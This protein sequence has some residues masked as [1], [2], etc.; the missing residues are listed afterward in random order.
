MNNL[1]PK[2]LREF[3]YY[4]RK[5]P[6]YL[7]NDRNFVEHFKIWYDI[8]LSEKQI[9]AIF[10][11]TEDG[12]PLVTENG[13]PIVLEGQYGYVIPTNILPTSN[14][15]LHLLNIYDSSYLESLSKLKDYN[16]NVS[17]I[18]DKLANLFS[19]SRN[20]KVTYTSNSSTI[21]EELHLNNEELLIFIKSQIIRNYCDGTYEQAMRYYEEAG[22]T[23]VLKPDETSGKVD[24][25]LNT[26]NMSENIQ[27]L[28]LS[29]NLTISHLGIEY[30]YSAVNL[31]NVLFWNVG[32]W[33]NGEDNEVLIK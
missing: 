1:L 10:L 14:L 5:L 19:I 28:F 32:L 33:S 27:K 25:L 20:I 9:D 7:R 11:S 29:G 21:V 18:L 22:L 24:I 12:I 6:L 16:E 15:I 31:A 3:K 26:V 2:E 13:E 30:L 17:D 8:L 23:V 4:E